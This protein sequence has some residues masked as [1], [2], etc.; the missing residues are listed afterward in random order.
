MED[1]SE[2]IIWLVTW[3]LIL[4][5]T[6]RSQW[7]QK[8]PSLGL[9]L[10]YL[11]SFSMIHFFGGLIYAFPWY[12]PKSGFLLQS[13]GTYTQVLEGFIQSL[14]GAV[15]FGVGSTILAY[16]IL[17]LWQPV[18]LLENPQEPDLQLP[19]RLLEISLLF[20]FII[21]PTIGKI[22]G[23]QGFSSSGVYLLVVSLCL[24]CW[25]AIYQKNARSFLL[26]LAVSF[27]F[28]V[29]T[30]FTMG[31]IGYGASATLV[32]L[33]FI[34]SFYRPRWQVLVAGIL[35]FVFGL[36]VYVTYMRDRSQIRSSVWGGESSASR[37]ERIAKTFS[38]FELISPFNQSHLEAIDGRLNQNVLV[39]KSVEYI[40]SG[41]Q[42]FALGATILQAALAPI[43]RVLWADKFTFG[44][45]GNIVSLYTGQKFGYGT[46]VG[47]GQ[48]LEFYINFGS[49]GVFVGFLILGV[50]IRIIDVVASHKLLSGNWLGFVFWFLPG[51]VAIQPG[52]AL[53]EITASMA[54]S[55][56]LMIVIGRFLLKKSSNG[57]VL[58]Q[59]SVNQE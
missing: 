15:G 14:Y 39:G 29:V 5:L 57:R 26:W 7:N 34:S 37:L 12:T 24:F 1:R 10:I 30:I 42:N 19:R 11:L 51:L 9:P 20:S 50:I 35:V 18:W 3:V 6:L 22:P 4:A 46:S 23:F 17:H 53:A 16:W 33:I 25:S 52:G 43:P 32:V 36:S 49:M 56:F 55:F 21:T 47:A 54:S 13:G 28:P 38:N 31:F 40:R 27:A 59:F 2:L 8:L 44:G 45:S 41:Q 58:N 48:V